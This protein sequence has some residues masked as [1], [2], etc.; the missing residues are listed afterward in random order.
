MKWNKKG[1]IYCPDGKT[2][3]AQQ[4]AMLP[5]P[6]LLEDK[7]RIYLGFCTD[8]NVGRIGYVDVD[9]DNP[10]KILRISESPVLDIGTKGAFDDNGVVPVSILQEDGKIYLYYVGFQLGVKV[11]YYMFTGLAISEDRGDTFY[12]Y[13]KVPVL[14]R[15]NEELCARCGTNIIK[16]NGIF[17]AWYIGSINNGWTS[18]GG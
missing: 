18:R 13:S 12:R 11:P 8:E 7:L 6:L 9:P 17:K 10:Q 2:D 4:F 1:L 14:D 3:W 5:T 15:N 16:D